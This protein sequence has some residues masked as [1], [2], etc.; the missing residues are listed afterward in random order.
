M[1]MVKLI[2]RFIYFNLSFLMKNKEQTFW[3]TTG[4]YPQTVILSFPQ[5]IEIKS[6]KLNCYGSKRVKFLK[7][8]FL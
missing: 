5:S 1:E 2:V 4:L 7:S 8:F 3:M 6:V